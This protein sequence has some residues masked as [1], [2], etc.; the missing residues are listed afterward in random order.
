M[1]LFYIITVF[2]RME[3]QYNGLHTILVSVP[4][5][6]T[7]KAKISFCIGGKK[8]HA[9]RNN[10]FE[11]RAVIYPHNDVIAQS[12]QIKINAH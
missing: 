9:P 12:Q 3:R 5:L 11:K 2:L 10:K 1:T 7:K 8:T 4:G 6:S